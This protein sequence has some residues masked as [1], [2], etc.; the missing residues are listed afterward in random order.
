MN[1][2][3]YDMVFYILSMVDIEWQFPYMVRV[4]RTSVMY[5][6]DVPSALTRDV[7]EKLH[8]TCL[9]IQLCSRVCVF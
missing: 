3:I 1:V 4:K 5:G 9:M 6:S 7:P 8:R 2:L